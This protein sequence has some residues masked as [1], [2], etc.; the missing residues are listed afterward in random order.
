M[1]GGGGVTPPGDPAVPVSTTPDSV[2]SARI[3]GVEM[4]VVDGVLMEVEGLDVPMLVAESSSAVSL[5]G[6]VRDDPGNRPCA[7][8]TG[9]SGGIEPLLDEASC[10]TRIAGT[11][12]AA[13][14]FRRQLVARRSL[15]LENTT[16]RSYSNAWVAEAEIWG[17]STTAPARPRGRAFRA[18]ACELRGNGSTLTLSTT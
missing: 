6:V 12:R 13:A 2:S 1:G 8:P 5:S 16:F 4:I 17:T 18:G 9:G 14:R 10:G 11:A 15:P 3:N 7:E